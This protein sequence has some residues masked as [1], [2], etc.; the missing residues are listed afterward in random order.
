L[1]I[2]IYHGTCRS[3]RND[4][5]KGQGAASR[6]EH[7]RAN[8]NALLLPF[9]ESL[10]YDIFN[11]L[12]VEPEFTVNIDP[13]REEKIDYAFYRDG[14]P[15]MVFEC[16]E[17]GTD[18]DGYDSEAF[19]RRFRAAEAKIGV[20][21]NGIV[22]RFFADLG[23]QTLA[24]SGLLLEFDFLDHGPEDIRGLRQ[25]IPITGDRHARCHS[26]QIGLECLF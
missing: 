13:D 20:L 18:F 17:A 4:K 21:T 2:E 23:E 26:F 22:Y 19:F 12:E 25:L 15:V 6:P 9:L 3:N 24:G 7:E 11:V 5:L 10:G 1:Q 14:T 8:E 16:A